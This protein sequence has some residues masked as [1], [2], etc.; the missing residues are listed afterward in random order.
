MFDQRFWLELR[1]KAKENDLVWTYLKNNLG[2][3]KKFREEPI[4]EWAYIGDQQVEE[5][6]RPCDICSPPEPIKA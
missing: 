5:I 2:V 4:F 3:S 1:N 6:F